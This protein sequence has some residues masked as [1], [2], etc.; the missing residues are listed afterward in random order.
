MMIWFLKRRIFFIDNLFLFYSFLVLI[1][2]VVHISR[3]YWVEGGFQMV[4]FDYEGGDGEMGF[5]WWLCNK[6]FHFF[7]KFWSSAWYIVF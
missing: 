4:T 1:I 3:S 7:H 5:G 2:G 6:N